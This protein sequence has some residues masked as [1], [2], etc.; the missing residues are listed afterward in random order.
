MSKLQ[1]LT[2]PS[3]LADAMKKAAA[4]LAAL[5]NVENALVKIEDERAPAEQR[6]TAARETLTAVEVADLIG[7]TPK[8]KD[9]QGARVRFDEAEKVRNRI[10]PTKKALTNKRAHIDIEVA[11]AAEHLDQAYGEFLED[12]CKA[13][14]EELS[15]AVREIEPILLQAYAVAGALSEMWVSSRLEKSQILHVMGDDH[16]LYHGRLAGAALAEKWRN[17]KTAR[18][19]HDVLAP[20]SEARNHI[21]HKLINVRSRLD[22]AERNA[23]MRRQAAAPAR[24][25]VHSPAMDNYE[26]PK[27]EGHDQAIP[28]PTSVGVYRDY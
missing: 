13:L 22:D 27:P 2:I 12:A 4:A 26:V 24:S 19:M 17:D 1:L 3:N 7:D 18:A 8:A 14:D 11:E 9:L 25:N 5:E 10:D 15:A 21:N 6:Y 23:E 20:A 16:P 28:L